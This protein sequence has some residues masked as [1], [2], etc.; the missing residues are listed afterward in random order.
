M[1]KKQQTS[2]LLQQMVYSCKLSLS[3]MTG[4]S[5]KN[6][7]ILQDFIVKLLCFE[8][9]IT[10]AVCESRFKY[11]NII[12]ELFPH[13]EISW[14]YIQVYVKLFSSTFQ[15]FNFVY[16]LSMWGRIIKKYFSRV[17]NFSSIILPSPTNCSR[18]RSS[19]RF[20]REFL[21]RAMPYPVVAN[22]FPEP[23]VIT[24]RRHTH[25]QKKNTNPSGFNNKYVFA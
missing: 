25:A 3:M 22:T 21:C 7:A 11:W 1:T 15:Y 14:F 20:Q 24:F 5:Q 18:A 12:I 13:S 8:V 6:A 10:G 17:F 19:G 4:T 16:V 23:M 9:R 2:I